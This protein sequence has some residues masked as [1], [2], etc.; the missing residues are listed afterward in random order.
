M[1]GCEDLLDSLVCYVRG[2][3]AD[4]KSDDKVP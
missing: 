3:I 4:F 2:A 1:R